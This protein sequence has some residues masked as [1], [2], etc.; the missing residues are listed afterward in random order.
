MLAA[1]NTRTMNRTSKGALT[2]NSLLETLDTREK[3]LDYVIGK[4]NRS[5]KRFLK[6]ESEFVRAMDGHSIIC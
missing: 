5:R 1:G 3:S 2:L 4:I 6:E